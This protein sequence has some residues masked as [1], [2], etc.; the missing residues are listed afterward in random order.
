MSATV[1]S[2]YD[3]TTT[4]VQIRAGR[5]LTLEVIACSF[6]VLLTNLL[7]IYLSRGHPEVVLV[8][9]SSPL[10]LHI[11][12]MCPFGRRRRL[13]HRY[14]TIHSGRVVSLLSRIHGS[15]GLCHRMYESVRVRR[16][17][18][19]HD[20]ALEMCLC[21]KQTPE[22]KAVYTAAQRCESYAEV[23]QDSFWRLGTYDRHW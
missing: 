5:Q 12:R 23:S 21:T 19:G 16:V 3:R 4:L 14:N 11:F 1:T 15:K 10:A 8:S 9:I 6:G 18:G 13:R 20:S 2:L 17:H 7:D 22:Q